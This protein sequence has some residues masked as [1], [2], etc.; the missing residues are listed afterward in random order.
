MNQEREVTVDVVIRALGIT[1][2]NG[3]PLVVPVDVLYTRID[4]QYIVKSAT[5]AIPELR[6]LDAF[7]SYKELAMLINCPRRS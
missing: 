3:T 2:K 5:V 4:S 7:L 1:S 6:C